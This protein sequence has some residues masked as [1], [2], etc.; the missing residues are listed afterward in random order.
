MT[1]II[2]SCRALGRLHRSKRS[3]ELEKK[4]HRLNYLFWESTLTCNLSC[5]H[6]GSSC[7]PGQK[8][9]DELDGPA[10]KKIFKEIASDFDASDICIAVTGGEPLT[11][12]DLFDVMGECHQLGF[13]WGMVSNG[14]LITREVIR[15]MEQTGMGTISLSIDGDAKGHAVLRGSEKAYDQALRGLGLILE[16]GQFL[17]PVEV[18]SVVHSRNVDRLEEAYAVFASMGVRYWRLLNIDPIGRMKEPGQQ[19]L[20]L[21]GKQFVRFLDF[22]VSKRE[23]GLMDVSFEESGFLG[24]KYEGRVRDWHF[25]CPAGISVASILH[26]GAIGACPS[27]GRNMVEGDGRRER[28]SDVWNNRYQRFRDRKATRYKGP[29]RQCTWWDFCEG[30]SLHLWDWEAEKPLNCAYQ[31]LRN[32]GHLSD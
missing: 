4:E 18:V 29:C 12:P 11:R 14:I 28:F 24:L 1:A 8:R 25:K 22:V 7:S 6:C 20:F 3:F 17:D 26:D 30:G 27:L 5:R 23:E 32:A 13:Y 15:Q 2:E 16:Y 9:A 21:N 19:D 10:I 31:L